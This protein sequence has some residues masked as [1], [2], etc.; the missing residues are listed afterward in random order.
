MKAGLSFSSVP[1]QRCINGGALERHG[2]K[3][4]IFFLMFFFFFFFS[5]VFLHF[6]YILSTSRLSINRAVMTNSYYNN[7]V[8][9]LEHGTTNV[10]KQ[11]SYSSTVVV[12]FWYSCA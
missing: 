3:Q 12:V 4:H 10:L 11:K 7:L 5:A 2:N 9:I 1:A 6:P 8:V